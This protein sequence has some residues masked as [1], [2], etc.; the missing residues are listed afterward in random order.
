MAIVIY[1]MRKITK[2]VHCHDY[3]LTNQKAVKQSDQ[4]R[5][6][7]GSVVEQLMFGSGTGCFVYNGKAFV[8]GTAHE[9]RH[10]IS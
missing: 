2:S 5:L 9:K 8:Y 3:I 1:C 4:L 7:S 10:N 6:V